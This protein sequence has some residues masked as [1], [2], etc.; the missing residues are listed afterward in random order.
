MK[1]CKPVSVSKAAFIFCKTTIAVI[2]WAALIFKIK[3]LVVM[4]FVLLALS[5]L[6]KIQRAPL[7]VLYSVTM[8][9]LLKSENE[10]L[11][12]HA[13]R[14]A[15]TMGS[16]LNLICILLLYFVS[17]SA[18]WGMVLIVT[19]AKT[20]GAM[21][22]CSALKLYGCMTSGKCCRFVRQKNA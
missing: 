2:L 13:M 15:H 19:I 6:L 1:V 18:G 4:S 21:G 5:A 20:A 16:V 3:W 11:D 8:N 10:I 7:I 9:K 22:F 12:E 14:F 17:E